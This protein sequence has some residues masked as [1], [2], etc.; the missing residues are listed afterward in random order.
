MDLEKSETCQVLK[1]I[2]IFIKKLRVEK[3]FFADISCF[4]NKTVLLT[5]FGPGGFRP[6]P[7][8]P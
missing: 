2:V 7:P 3:C 6:H 4:I 8:P 5:L 1:I